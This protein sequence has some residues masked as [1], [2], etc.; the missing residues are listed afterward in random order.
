MKMSI[1]QDTLKRRKVMNSFLEEHTYSL[2]RNSAK[3]KKF[4]I[5]PLRNFKDVSVLG[6]W[7]SPVPSG[8]LA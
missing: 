6:G 4:S 1:M 3:K 8:S 2:F 5:L 7:C